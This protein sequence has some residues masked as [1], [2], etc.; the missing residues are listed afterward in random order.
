M[1]TVQRALKINTLQ[2]MLKQMPLSAALL[3]PVIVLAE[4]VTSGSQPLVSV[5]FTPQ[6]LGVIV[7]T[8]VMAFFVNVSTFYIIAELSAIRC[9][10][11]PTFPPPA[12]HCFSYNVLGHC[13][14]CVI[15]VGGALMFRE[16]ARDSAA[17]APDLMPFFAD[18]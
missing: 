15:I 12:S 4:D 10:S 8:A 6:L 3:L 11:P 14:T 16:V 1:G 7:V 5:V 17:A 2:L 18:V 9:S 13:K